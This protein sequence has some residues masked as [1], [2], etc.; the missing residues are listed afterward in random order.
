MV[1]VDINKGLC[2][3]EVEVRISKGQVNRDSTVPTKSVMGIINSHLFTLFNFLNFGL[4]FAVVLV[5]SYKN[6]TFLGIVII[7]TLIG[8]LQE[9]NAKRIIDKL[10]LLNDN[11]VLVIRDGQK[12]YI[13][14]NEIV[15]DDLIILKLGDQVICDSVILDGDCEVNESFVTGE[16]RS[17]YK[18]KGDNLL[19]GS[20]IV[21]GEIKTQVKHVATD[22]YTSKIIDEIKVIKKPNSELM[23]SLKKIIKYISITIVPLGILLFTK[24]MSLPNNNIRRAVLST[25][26]AMIG[27]IPEGLILLTSTVLAVS[28]IRLARYKVLIQQLY[29]VETLA[30]IDTICL[31]KTGTLT[32]GLVE[33]INFIPIEEIHNIDEIISSLA[34]NLDENNTVI[35]LKTRFPLTVNWDVVDKRM[36]SSQTKWSGIN[37]ARQGTYVMGAPEFVMKE[38]YELIK[39][40]VNQYVEE[41]RVLLLAHSN[42]SFNKIGLPK[43]LK[44]I[45]LILLRDKIR[46]E[47]INTLNFFEK[48]GVNI[49]IISGDNVLTVKSI[50]KRVG[51]EVYNKYIDTSLIE[52]EQQLREAAI[53]YSIFGR[54]SPNQKK[55][56]VNELKKQN[57]VVGFVGDGVNDTLALREADCGVAMASGS[58]AARN[59]SELILLDSNFEAMPYVVN[60]GRRT[61]NNIERSAT[62]FLAKTIFATVLAIVFLFI[63]VPYPFEPIQLSLT[64]VFTIGIPSFILAIEPNNEKIS[65]NFLTNVISKSMPT[66]LTNIINIILIMILGAI[67]KLSFSETSTMSVILMAFT[68]FMLLAKI[69]TPFN[70]IRMGLMVFGISGFLIG[71]LGLP[72]LFSLTSISPLLW[73][74]IISLIFISVNNF[75]KF[76]NLYYKIKKKYPKIFD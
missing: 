74:M 26:A 38:D 58:E 22:N 70:T 15:V 62:L 28:V 72:S 16:A 3:Q 10:S 69:S 59:V 47:A 67:F 23:H 51:M 24:Q 20:F 39:P 71:V 25:V 14:P 2:Q 18:S 64:S 29:S 34:F 12:K 9:L 44:P 68:G 41:Y 17:L 76:T 53:K 55:I 7:N 66:A 19:S 1:K 35:A 4:A 33:F 54:V 36:F 73:L 31:D 50:A 61:I 65:G 45:G 30:R 43:N 46:E 49:K 42:Y 40:I 27:M 48:Q 13:E 11:R 5:D 37:F 56:I 75:K 8:I 52:D 60:E 6:L 21:S 32:D 63:S 57:H